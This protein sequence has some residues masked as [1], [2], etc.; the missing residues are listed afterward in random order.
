MTAMEQQ[1]PADGT[2]PTRTNQGIVAIVA[3]ALIYIFTSFMT[4]GLNL[5]I[6]YISHD[7]QSDAILLSWVVSSYLLVVAVLMIPFGRLGDILGLKKIFLLGIIVFV[8]AS[9]LAAFS[10]SIILLIIYRSLQAVGAAMI[11]STGSAII[12]ATNPVNQRG[13]AFGITTA[14]VY[15]GYAAGPFLG[16]ILTEHLGWRSMFLINIPAGVLILFLVLW[17][18]K[19]EWSQSKREKF[20]V[21]GSIIY[22]ISLMA[23]IYGFS[24]LPEIFGGVLTLVGI[25]G[26]IIFLNLETRTASPILNINIFRS[27]KTFLF[28]N[29]A[30]L[31]AYCAT[32]AITFLL[33][34]YL[35]YIRALSPEQAGWILVSQPIILAILAP[36]MG[37]LAEKIEPRIISSIGMT[38]TCIGLFILIF[39]DSN[40]S[41]LNII[42]VLLVIGLGLAVFIPPNATAVINSVE[43][44]YYGIATAING[45]GRTIGQTLSMGITTIVMAVVIG[46]VVI[47]STYFPA[48]V[49]STK[50]VFGIFSFFCLIGIFISLSRGNI[51][52][53]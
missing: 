24:L 14:S 25:M 49:T 6:P 36:V 29:I 50:I 1:R 22:G 48:F 5:A 32:F 13:R 9:T 43:P 21:R 30:N 41:L 35:Q 16:G 26:I 42:I 19:G 27:N 7:F 46:R 28:S 8:V 37:R 52:R 53:S 20:D 47:T 17:K 45:T 12:A 40:T 23:L 18:I 10:N 4:S 11:F 3:C 2:S 39:L 38:L 33:S 31:I 15:F 44:K 34:L 51:N